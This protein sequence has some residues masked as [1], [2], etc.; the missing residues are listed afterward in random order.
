MRWFGVMLMLAAGLLAGCGGGSGSSSGSASIRLMNATSGY[1]ALDLSIDGAVANTGVAFGQVGAY[2]GAG[3]SGVSTVISE[4]GSST[5]LS[6]SSRTLAKDEHYTLLVYGSTGALKTALIDENAA[7][8]ASGFTSLQIMN[9]APDAGTV[10]VYLTGSSDSL[11]NAT[12]TAS[13]V[14]TSGIVPYAAISAGTYRLRVTGTGDK[15]D[16]RLDVQGLVLASTQVAT[17][18]LTEGR[19][20]VLVNSALLVQ[21]GSATPLANTQARLQLISAVTS[22]ASVTANVAGTAVASAAVAPNIGA[23]TLVTGSTAA[24]VSL[25]V[26]GT[27]V[28]V[29]NQ[30]LL[31]GGDYTLLVWGDAAAPQTTLVTDD[32]RYP[33]VSGNAKIRLVNGTSGAALPLTLKADFSVVAPSIAQGQASAYAS[34]VAS[35]TSRLDVASSSN[36]AVYSDTVPIV[37][38]GLYTLYMLGDAGAPVADLRK[39]R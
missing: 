26:N 20:G 38:K 3:T 21:Q 18:V 37:A 39:L 14:T 8:A 28:A 36:A 31:P 2:A 25:A 19:G 33:A 16:L 7:A 24:P 11:D 5:A 23:Y 1:D 35:T 6:T 4:T 34:V 13:G 29:A 12:P 32:N 22:G 17:L 27:A 30:A 15:T 10:D 9:L